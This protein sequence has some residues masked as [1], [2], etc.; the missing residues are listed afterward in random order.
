MTTVRV[1]R[2]R[3]KDGTPCIS[4]IQAGT[5]AKY[6]TR[7]DFLHNGVIVASVVQGEDRAT[8][9]MEDSN[10]DGVEVVIS[11]DT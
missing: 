3:L 7:V 1:N 6:G 4:V 5:K 9:W 8:V 2:A 11:G 10:E